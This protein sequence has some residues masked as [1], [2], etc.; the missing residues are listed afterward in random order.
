MVAFQLE[1]I[2]GRQDGIFGEGVTE[3]RWELI[4]LFPDADIIGFTPYLG[5]IFQDSNAAEQAKAVSV[6][7]DGLAPLGGEAIA[8]RVLAAAISRDSA[9]CHLPMR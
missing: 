4:D 2:S 8:R 9:C 7:I 3:P 1:S 6:I 5:L